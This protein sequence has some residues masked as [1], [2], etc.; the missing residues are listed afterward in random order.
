MKTA[1]TFSRRKFIA[2]GAGAAAAAAAGTRLAFDAHDAA[3]VNFSGPTI[4]P[5]DRIGIQ[6]YTVRDRVS[7]IGFAKVFEALAGIGYKGIEFAGYT[8][9]SV[10]P[11]TL[12]QIRSLLDA[13][14]L[15]GIGSHVSPSDQNIGRLLDEAEILGLPYIG[16]SF[17]VPPNTTKSGWQQYAE[18]GNR[19]GALAKARGIK[20][21]LHNHFQEFAPTSDDPTTRGIDVLITEGE[22]DLLYFEYDIYWAYVGQHLFGQ[23]PLAF[24]PIDYVLPRKSRFPLFHVKDGRRNTASAQ[25]YEIADV[26][27]GSIDFEDFFCRVGEPP[28]HWYL[29]ENDNGAD[30]PMGSLASAKFSYMNMRYG[31][32]GCA[33]PTAAEAQ[34]FAARRER[35][36][37][38]VSWST[39]SEVDLLGFHVWR[40]AGG[41]M[42]RVNAKLVHAKHGGRPR[43]ASYRVL[44]HGTRGGVDY[45]YRLQA[46]RRDGT[47][48][49]AAST[50]YPV[51]G[52]R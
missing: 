2:A 50:T 28:E 4:L 52:A 18:N 23:G 7:S 29:N 35:R 47:R 51:G 27:E 44:D 20:L 25:G 12:E 21:Y 16:I 34:A 1:R 15:K 6:L 40:S 42:R 43:G 45:T 36:G 9:G 30:H 11:I 38:A 26:G 37:V 5:P 32:Q 41:R 17:I 3:A 14:G 39:A 19:W 13:N 49:W 31:L 46:V 8:Q 22:P 10:G 48:T 24:Q 33:G